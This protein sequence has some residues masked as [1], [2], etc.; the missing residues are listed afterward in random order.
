MKPLPRLGLL[1]RPQEKLANCSFDEKDLL[2]KICVLMLK[3]KS[4]FD[5]M[6]QICCEKSLQI[7]YW[8]WETVNYLG[9]AAKSLLVGA[10]CGVWGVGCRFLPILIWSIT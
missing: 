6:Y 8:G 3:R 10:G 9:F 1:I 2:P 5:K 4:F 7:S